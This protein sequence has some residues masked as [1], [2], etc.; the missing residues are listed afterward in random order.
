MRGGLGAVPYT[1]RG[2]VRYSRWLHMRGGLGAV[3]ILKEGGARYI[4]WLQI[5]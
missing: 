3:P 1:E 5:K 4:R 2:G